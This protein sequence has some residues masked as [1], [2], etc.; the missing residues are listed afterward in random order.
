V[1][2]ALSK[3]AARSGSGGTR[4]A[5]AAQ[6]IAA[7]DKVHADFVRVLHDTPAW[8][9]Y[10]ACRRA[11]QDDCHNAWA[12][13]VY[14]GLTMG[15]YTSDN[16]A[17]GD[18]LLAQAGFDALQLAVTAQLRSADPV[19]R[20]ATLALIDFN[21]HLKRLSLPYEAYTDLARRSIVEGQLIL[22][23]H[24]FEALPSDEVASEVHAMCTDPA[25]DSRI[26]PLAVRA[27][28]HPDYAAKLLDVTRVWL[29]PEGRD[30]LN[31]VMLLAAL[32]RCGEP[33][34]AGIQAMA[35]DPRPEVRDHAA[36][37]LASSR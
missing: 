31:P 19:Q 2:G 22:E 29:S 32:Q 25:A 34:A 20:I 15:V 35:D 7:L 6:A 16:E 27:L 21:P 4:R 23:R 18:R 37:I 36:T 24:I 13:A 33:C 5:L 3:A 10:E 9:E 12:T 26:W 17:L 30:M 11:G 1:S 28:G 14:L 8:A